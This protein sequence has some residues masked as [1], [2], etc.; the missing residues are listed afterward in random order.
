MELLLIRHARPLRAH[1]GDGPADPS[2]SPLGVRQSEALADWLADEPLG[3]I[4]TSPLRRARETAAPL[5]AK[6]GL[7]VAIDDSL[8]EY[9]AESVEYIPME[10]LKAAG[11]PRWNEVPVALPE[12]RER[13]IA[14]IE[15]LVKAHASERIAVVCHG[16]V[17]NVYVAWVV[18]SR[19]ELFFL[20]H[21]T[22]ISRVLAS[23]SGPRSIDTINE[24]AHL[25]VA[26][27]PLVELGRT[28]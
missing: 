16:G 5:A 1:G 4:Y 10:E 24:T 23:G 11:D 7:D 17:I 3:A 14:G 28:G 20:P 8:R 2:L 26:D 25:R 22:S 19:T 9:D 12:F 18:R 6:L 27:V 21:Y 13:V 15:G